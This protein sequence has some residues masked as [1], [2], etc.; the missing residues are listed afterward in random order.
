MIFIQ[1]SPVDLPHQR[2]AIKGVEF[3]FTILLAAAS[4]PRHAR[5]VYNCLVH[6]TGF[7]PV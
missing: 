5:V 6:W 3:P 7:E 1:L 2:G 4:Q